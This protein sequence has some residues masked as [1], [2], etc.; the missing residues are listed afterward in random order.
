MKG[1]ACSVVVRAVE[2][3]TAKAQEL[4]RWLTKC[5]WICHNIVWDGY[6]ESPFTRT[7]NSSLDWC[8]GIDEKCKMSLEAL[9]EALEVRL[10]RL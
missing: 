6:N 7:R 10:R 8:C 4:Y 9:S 2:D 5:P 1:I 3:G